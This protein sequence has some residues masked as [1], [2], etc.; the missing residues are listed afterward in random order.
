LTYPALPD[1]VNSNIHPTNQYD[2]RNQMGRLDGRVAIVTGA[3]GGIGKQ[4]ALLLARE[5]ARRSADADAVVAEIEAVGGNGVA[6]RASATWDGASE[7]V[8][9]AI[10]HFGRLD[11]LINNAT[12]AG[13]G[14]LWKITEDQFD[15]TFNVNTKG[16]FALMQAAIP[17]MA[18][19]G[20][21]AIVNTSSS[22]GFGDPGN[23]VYSAAKEAVVGLTRTGGR[24]L[25]RFGI[26]V[27][28]IRPVA[29]GASFS[30]Y[31]DVMAKW[32][33]IVEKATG[34]RSLNALSPEVYSP[35]KVA[36]FAVWLC[37][38]AAHGVNGRVFN[39]GGGTVALLGDETIE[40][41][42]FTEAGWTLDGLDES[43]PRSATKGL[44]NPWT[45][46]GDPE[47]CTWD[48]A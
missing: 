26:R 37:T 3:G 35:E 17:H 43:M 46:D 16:Y 36:A 30:K 13:G 19:Q 28:A 27:N 8:E 34:R 44:T 6:S 29:L 33:K 48:E 11:I 24:E 9:T 25:G 20:S 42:V 1:G 15:L 31:A 39:V 22:A 23:S 21:G 38:D 10:E 12:A 14:D 41:A 18:R 45:L 7:I 47:L 4:H 40:Q 5:G 2:R 32:L